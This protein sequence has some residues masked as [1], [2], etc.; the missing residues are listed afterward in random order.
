VEP[1]HVIVVGCGR[2]GS[3]LTHRLLGEGHSVAIVDK[4]PDAFRRL[5][6][7]GART[8][9]GFG[10]DRETLVE[11]GVDR[12]FGFAAV[13]SGDNSNI[14]SAR[15]AR[16]VYG[17]PNVVA[18]IYDPRRAVVYERLGIQTVAT[19]TWTTDQALGR[20]FPMRVER[21]WV[22]STG[23]LTVV[24]LT[25]PPEAIGRSLEELERSGELSVVALV[26]ASD[27]RLDARRAVL[28]EGD[29]VVVAAKRAALEELGAWVRADTAT[30][31]EAR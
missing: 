6:A 20:L 12:A 19:V 31:P 1:Q 16:D 15:I 2:V 27:V 21:P 22:D 11:A 18:R 26:R 24:E 25:V 23:E 13:T 17:V 7:P 28:Q 10:F 30:T 14:L 8:V 5:H 3:E 4:N 29:R 9:V